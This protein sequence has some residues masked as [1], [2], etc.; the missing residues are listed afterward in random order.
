MSIKQSGEEKFLS[1]GKT[2]TKADLADHLF[3][4]VG[5]NKREAKEFVDLFFDELRTALMSEGSIKLT[6]F[7]NFDVRKKS[8]RP[9]RNPKTGQ[10][11]PVTARKVVTFHASQKLKERMQ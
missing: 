11:I 8:E 4:K 2:V 9:G 5:L 1:I 3:E 7:G 6:G 10:Q